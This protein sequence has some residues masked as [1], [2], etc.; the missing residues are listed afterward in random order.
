MTN[1]TDNLSTLSSETV[2]ALADGCTLRSGASDLSGLTSGEYV[3]LCDPDGSE[4]L[5]YHYPEW[6]E[7]PIL[8][9]GALMNAAAGSRLP[10]PLTDMEGSCVECGGV[11]FLEEGVSYH[12]SD[13]SMDGIDHDL[14]LDHTALIDLDD[15]GRA[16]V[17]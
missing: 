9:M 16:V 1:D 5:Y 13:D 4:I 3:R 17:S 11:V 12:A 10:K 8:V 7:D 15:Q 6:E 2:V 14:D